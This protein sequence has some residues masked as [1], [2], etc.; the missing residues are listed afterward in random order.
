MKTPPENKNIVPPSPP[1][2]LTAIVPGVVRIRMMPG[3]A[4]EGKAGPGDVVEVD[5]HTADY[6]IKIGYAEE[7]E[8]NGN[9]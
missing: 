5:R 8:K 7:E 2:S 6:L 4:L 9:Q 3:R 1:L